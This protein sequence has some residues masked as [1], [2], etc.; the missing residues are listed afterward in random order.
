MHM[1]NNLYMG[2]PWFARRKVLLLS[3]MQLQ[4][5]NPWDL[6]NP[7]FERSKTRATHCLMVPIP[8]Q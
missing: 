2:R 4:T 1:M 6:G 5:L 3:F 7:C 8:Y